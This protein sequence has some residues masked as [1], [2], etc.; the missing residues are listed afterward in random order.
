MKQED[1]KVIV[2]KMVKAGESAKTI[3]SFIKEAAKR[4]SLG[5]KKNS[6]IR[7]TVESPLAQRISDLPSENT[8]SESVNQTSI[9]MP[10]VV[11]LHDAQK[12][13][14]YDWDEYQRLL[15]EEEEKDRIT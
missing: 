4:N 5:K 11:P 1:V 15:K 14:T 8:S 12:Y 3:E 7:A 9:Y 2:K 10:R 6:A 13:G